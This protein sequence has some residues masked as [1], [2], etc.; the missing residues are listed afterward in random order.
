MNRRS[1][2]R[3]LATAALVIASPVAIVHPATWRRVKSW[4]AGLLTPVQSERF[5]ELALD[6]AHLLAEAFTVPLALPAPVQVMRVRER[7]GEGPYRPAQTVNPRTVRIPAGGSAVTPPR[8]R[9][10]E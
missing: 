9:M 2:L 5:I 6:Q 8:K 4:H 1:F 7:H 3:G 10:R